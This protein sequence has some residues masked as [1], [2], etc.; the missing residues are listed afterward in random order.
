MIKVCPSCRIGRLGLRPMVYIEW[1]GEN[2]LV[3]NH[4]PAEVCDVCGERVY[5]DEAIEN[6]QRLLWSKPPFF[7]RTAYNRNS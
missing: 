2:L 4:M 5:D 1:H 7:S 3:A 6:L